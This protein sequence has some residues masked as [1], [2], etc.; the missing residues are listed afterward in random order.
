MTCARWSPPRAGKWATQFG[1][2]VGDAMDLTTGWGFT[3]E[4]DRNSAEACVD[5]EKPLVLIGS[6][7]VLRSASS[8]H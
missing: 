2:E 7:P 5:K 8:T 1:T 3:N 4:E 6:L